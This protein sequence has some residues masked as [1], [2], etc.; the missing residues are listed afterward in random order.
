MKTRKWIFKGKPMS[1]AQLN[2]IGFRT[3]VESDGTLGIAGE[4]KEPGN[5]TTCERHNLQ[6]YT[7]EMKLKG[8]IALTNPKPP[9]KK[10]ENK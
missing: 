7:E 6:P 9:A 2:K 8:E 3:G 5:Y 4:P 1:Q 10:G